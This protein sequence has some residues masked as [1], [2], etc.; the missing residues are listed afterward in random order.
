[1]NLDIDRIYYHALKRGRAL[2]CKLRM[3]NYYEVRVDATP[4][5]MIVAGNIERVMRYYLSPGIKDE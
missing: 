4:P 1:M 5:W 3:Q 2:S